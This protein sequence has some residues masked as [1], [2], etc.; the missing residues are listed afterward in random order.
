VLPRLFY[1]RNGHTMNLGHLDG[2]PV[3]IGGVGG[4]YSPSNF[5]RLSKCL[6]GYANCHYTRDEIETLCRV[7]GHISGKGGTV[8]DVGHDV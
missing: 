8:I 5:E 6:H 7:S 1:L 2:D 4:C 3:R